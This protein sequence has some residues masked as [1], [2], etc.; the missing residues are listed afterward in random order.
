MP[1]L[2]TPP[3][4]PPQRIVSLCP[5]VTETVHALGAWARLVG[6]TR[7]CVHP[8][9]L[10]QSVPHVRG[11]KNPDLTRLMELAPDLVVAVKEENRL[12]DIEELVLSGVPLLLLDPN[13]IEEAVDAV[14]E[15]GD[16]LDC[17][18]QGELLARRIRSVAQ[19]AAKVSDSRPRVVYLIWSDPLMAVGGGTFI[20]SMLEAG[21]LHDVLGDRVRYPSLTASDIT[22]LDPAAVLLS[23]EPFPFKEHHRTEL[24]QATGLPVDRFHLVDGELL[25]WHG[26]RT[27]RGLRYSANLAAM[28]RGD[29]PCF[30]DLDHSGESESL[31]GPP[32]G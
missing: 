17:P 24:A 6:R 4:A 28:L 30:L 32:T 14:R 31:G 19:T 5:S 18:I 12:E 26:A 13:S 20:H 16:A 1:F 3:A 9:G 15:L 23:S 7:Y 27:T 8:R 21:G 11:T 2:N 25:S 29:S 10:V 22:E